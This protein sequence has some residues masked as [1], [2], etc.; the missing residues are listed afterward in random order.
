MQTYVLI[1]DYFK[2][3]KPSSAVA[4]IN[5]DTASNVTEQESRP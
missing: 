4:K 2:V 3:Q 1:A 5:Y